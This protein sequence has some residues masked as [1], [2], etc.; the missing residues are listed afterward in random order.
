MMENDENQ[1]AYEHSLEFETFAASMDDGEWVFC[2]RCREEYNLPEGPIKCPLC[3]TCL[4]CD[5]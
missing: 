3:G 4:V 5:E 1:D 2:S